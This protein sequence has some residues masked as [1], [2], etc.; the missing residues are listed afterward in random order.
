MV[1]KLERMKYDQK[2]R[3]I[4]RQMTLDEKIKLMGGKVSMARMLYDFTFGGGYNSKPYPAGGNPRLGVPTLR[5]CDG[6]RGVVSYKST[7]FPVPMARGASFDTEL[8]E[9]VGD[10]IG[11]E[12]RG[13]GGN[14]FGGVCINIPYNPGWG[15]SQEVYSEDTCHMGK[16]GVASVRGIQKHNVMA[17]IKHYAF[18]SMENSRF[19]VSVKASKRTEREVFLPHFKKCIEAGAASVMSAYNKYQGEHCGHNNYLLKD[20]LKKEWDFDGFVIS[21][22]V[23]GIRDTSGGING[24]CDVEMCNTKY[25]KASKVKKCIKEGLIKEETI[26]E[27][28]VRIVRTILAFEGA[29]DPQSYDRSLNSCRDH[30]ALSREVAEKSI[31]L[32]KNEERVLPFDLSKT[33]KIALVG[34]LGKTKNIGDHGSSQVRPP[35]ITT[36]FYSLKELCPNAQVEFISTKDAADSESIIANAD[37]VVIACGYNYKDEGEFISEKLGIGGD[38]KASLGLHQEEIQMIKDIGHVNKN[39]SVVMYGGN[40]IMMTDWYDNVSSIIMAYYPGMEGGRAIV[41]ILFGKVNPSGKLPYAVPKY[42]SDLPQVDWNAE[43]QEYDYYHGYRKLEKEGKEPLL[44]FGYGLSFTDFEIS[45]IQISSVNETEAVFTAKVKNVGEM[46]GGEVVQLYVGFEK[47]AVDRPVKALK[48]FQKVYLKAGGEKEVILKV[49]KE[50][51][52]YYDEEALEWKMEDIGYIAYIG[53]NSEDAKRTA[54]RFHY[55]VKIR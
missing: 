49:S 42:E 31:T 27:N 7:C 46:I 54:I 20:V 29:K 30:I 35:Y 16:M 22:F 47:S 24:G 48:D 19:K 5:F 45:D 14:Y 41:D 52:G 23:W 28:A 43:E 33:K 50:D 36:L 9:R 10:A 2:A 13:A 17:C 3:E 4:V 15:R 44:P 21:D 1:T 55:P 38:R 32:L 11:K 37:A 25:Y 53:N 6:P 40:M 8:E 39:T 18:N 26:D 51:L 12:V 34:D